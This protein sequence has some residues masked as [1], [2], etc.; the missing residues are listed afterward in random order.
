MANE[1]LEKV[2]MN[3]RSRR[4]ALKMS[5]QELAIRC[6][7][8]SKASISL[9]E[10]GK[11]DTT[12]ETFQQIA[13]A[14]ECS[15]NDLFEGI[16]FEYGREKEETPTEFSVEAVYNYLMKSGFVQEGKDLSEADLRFLEAQLMSIASWFNKENA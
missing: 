15:A 4:K 5:Q 7:L 9:I 1:F 6:G 2:G 13:K 14:L 12:T 16:D 10:L 11:R 8:K 3:I